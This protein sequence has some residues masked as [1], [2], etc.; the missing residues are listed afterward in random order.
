[1]WLESGAE[2]RT[3]KRVCLCLYCVMCAY[4]YAYE[5]FRG[6]QKLIAINIT[7]NWIEINKLA[8]R[9]FVIILCNQFHLKS[10]C[11]C[12]HLLCTLH[13]LMLSLS[14]SLYH[15]LIH[16]WFCSCLSFEEKFRFYWHLFRQIAYHKWKHQ[17]KSNVLHAHTRIHT[18]SKYFWLR[19][20]RMKA[21]WF[22]WY[23]LAYVCE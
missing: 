20:E 9:W 12:P 8:M 10:L 14:L 19:T 3:N 1:M 11:F 16:E 21:I 6:P 17:Y 22:R 13:T 23:A 7:V 2:F 5:C 15:S 4:M 18:C